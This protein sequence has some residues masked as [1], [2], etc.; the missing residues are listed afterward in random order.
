MPVS[1]YS[2][3]WDRDFDR[4]D[5]Q[6]AA[7]EKRMGLVWDC[8]ANALYDCLDDSMVYIKD[9]LDDENIDVRRSDFEDIERVL[10]ELMPRLRKVV[11]EVV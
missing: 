9:K 4:Y 2:D 6:E 11:D 7:E 8:V 5:K 3:V 1:P 10:S